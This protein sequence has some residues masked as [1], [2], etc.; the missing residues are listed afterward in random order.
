MIN[1]DLAHRH[2]EAIEEGL[3]AR[4]ALD[5]D[6]RVRV[7]VARE[8]LLEA[9]RPGG[10]RRPEEDGVALPCRD[11]PRAPRDEGAQKDVADLGVA[12]D[13]A[14]ERLGVEEEHVA[15]GLHPS[16]NEGAA[17]REDA[18]LAGEL[19]RLVRG[20][21]VVAADPRANDFDRA[22]KDDV[23]VRDGLALIEEDFTGRHGSLLRVEGDAI[24]LGGRQLRKHLRALLVRKVGHAL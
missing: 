1:G 22:R 16:A 9:E 24:D 10:V 12:L 15:G 13:D 21:G 3:H 20:D 11:Q 17:P 2:V 6:V 7:R 14:A 23:D 8:E 5:V 18:H 19:A 4:V